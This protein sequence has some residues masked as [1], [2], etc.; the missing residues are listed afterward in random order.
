MLRSRAL[1]S[2]VRVSTPDGAAGSRLPALLALPHPQP[3]LR[4]IFARGSLWAWRFGRLQ[5]AR[6]TRERLMADK[7]EAGGVRIASDSGGG[8]G[9]GR[10]PRR[11][12]QAL[13]RACRGLDD[14]GFGR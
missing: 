8:A 10:E 12:P 4:T 5:R 9:E 11:L 1:R 3:F 14:P 7:K 2:G 13:R 6:D